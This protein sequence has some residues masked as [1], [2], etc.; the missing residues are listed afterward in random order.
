MLL[1]Y[2]ATSY[3]KRESS[4]IIQEIH[5][6]KVLYPQV[7]G[8]FF[9]EQAISADGVDFYSRLYQAARL[10]F[11]GGLVIGNSGTNCHH[12]YFTAPCADLICVV[13]NEHGIEQY[14]RPDRTEAQVFGKT[15]AILHSQ[16]PLRLA[17]EIRLARSRG[18]FYIYFTDDVLPN[19]WD[20][21]PSYWDELV[22]AASRQ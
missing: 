10:E 4:Q 12:R 21:L 13:E 7:S 19:P 22:N 18:L 6:W 2:I 16:T 17:D 15:A 1:G 11:P 9:D 3:G 14:D 20:R 5:S 8:I